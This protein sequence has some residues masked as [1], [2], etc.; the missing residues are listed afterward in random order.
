MEAAKRRR[1]PELLRWTVAWM[2]PTRAQDCTS[3]LGCHILQMLVVDIHGVRDL[4]DASSSGRTHKFE[5]GVEEEG[6]DAA[7]GMEMGDGDSEA[8]RRVQGATRDS[9]DGVG[10]HS[11]ASA[12]RQAE[13]DGRLGLYGDRHRQHSIAQHKGEDGL[14]NGDG[15]PTKMKVPRNSLTSS[16]AMPF[17]P[18]KSWGRTALNAPTASTAPRS[19]QI[20]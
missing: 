4:E 2:E 20:V 8:D 12:D 1:E 19:S 17:S 18:P 3:S 13:H 15:S 5:G 10:A 7:S 11:K 14:C 6:G 9:A 16:A